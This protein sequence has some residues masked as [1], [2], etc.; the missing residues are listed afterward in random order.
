MLWCSSDLATRI[1]QIWNNIPLTDMPSP[2]FFARKKW[3][4]FVNWFWLVWQAKLFETNQFNYNDIINL[5]TTNFNPLVYQHLQLEWKSY[6]I[7]ILFIFVAIA[8]FVQNWHYVLTFQCPWKSNV[9]GKYHTKVWLTVSNG[10][11]FDWLFKTN[12]NLFLIFD[13]RR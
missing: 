1:Q 4:F 5:L 11:W 8:H 12:S 9:C 3:H 13:F 6:R 10:V 7:N 2:F